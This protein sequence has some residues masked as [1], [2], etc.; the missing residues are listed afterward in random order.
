MPINPAPVIVGISGGSG[1]GKTY[2]LNKLIHEYPETEICLLS[3][4]H[5]YKPLHTHAIDENGSVNWDLPEGIDEGRLFNDIMQLIAGKQVEKWEYT[6]NHP[7]FEPSLMLFKPAPILVIEGLFVFHL[8][9][10]AGMLDLRVFIEANESLRL[11]RRMIRD[12]AERSL[13]SEQILYQWNYHVKPAHEHYLTPYISSCDLTIL[14]EIGEPSL[15]SLHHAIDII[16]SSKSYL[17]E[18]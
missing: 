10:I 16:K 11:E 7:E 3:Q 1:C 9:R 13:S 18:K 4:D 6:F 17:S 15:V 14:N 12:M 8:E 2:I 5:Y